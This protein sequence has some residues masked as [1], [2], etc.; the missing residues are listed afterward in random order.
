MV[1]LD[2]AATTAF[3]QGQAAELIQQQPRLSQAAVIAAQRQNSG[4]RESLALQ[5]QPGLLTA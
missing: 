4:R 5:L 1:Q 2:A 3:L